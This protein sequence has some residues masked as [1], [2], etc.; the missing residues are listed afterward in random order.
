MLARVLSANA[1]ISRGFWR[2]KGASLAK[3]CFN[4]LAELP[5]SSSPCRCRCP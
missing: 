4:I 3:A 5:F 2:T 1:A